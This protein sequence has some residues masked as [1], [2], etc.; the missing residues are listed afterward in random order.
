MQENKL[1]IP[2]SI[3]IAGGLISW[4]LFATRAP[5][6]SFSAETNNN[7]QAQAQIQISVK[8]SDHI[9]GSPNA[10]IKMIT[11]TDFECSY[12]KIF[13]QTMEQIM[14]EYAKDERVS[15]VVRHFPVHGE[16]TNTKAIATECA[17]ELGGESKFWE[18]GEKIFETDENG[19]TKVDQLG[20]VAQSIG[21]NQTEFLA[22]LELEDKAKKIEDDY[23][24]GIGIGIEGTPHTIVITESGE[25]FPISGAQPYDAVRSLIEMI[26]AE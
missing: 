13:H 3:I 18:M 22:C 10:K 4:G 21:L 24:S 14:S 2:F 26:L 20:T 25:I 8:E 9:L 15:W 1:L 17:A 7:E 5:A 16:S 12:C 23:Q 6:E 11:F 19:W